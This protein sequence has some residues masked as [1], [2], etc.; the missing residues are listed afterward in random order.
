MHITYSFSMP[1]QA[2]PLPKFG[3][4]DVNNPAS[5]ASYSTI[6]DNFREEKRAGGLFENVGSKQ[7][8]QTIASDQKHRGY[9]S[10]ERMRSM[11]SKMKK[12][13]CCG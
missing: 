10:K 11:F 5:A 8:Y 7:K 3:E 6:F 4:W 12:W 2:Q 13:A 9:R 1:K